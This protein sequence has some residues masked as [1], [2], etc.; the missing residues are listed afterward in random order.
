MLATGLE[1]PEPPC[2]GATPEV[3]AELLVLYSSQD[4]PPSKP[5]LGNPAHSLASWNIKGP[6]LPL[7]T[8]SFVTCGDNPDEEKETNFS[9]IPEGP[10][11]KVL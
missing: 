2:A 6:D 3:T 8:V 4:F 9:S 11:G 5:H 1:L 10:K 7:M